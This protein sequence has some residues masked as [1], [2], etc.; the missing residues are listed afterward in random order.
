VTVAPPV[1]SAEAPVWTPARS[2]EVATLTQRALGPFG[3]ADGQ[4]GLVAWL[5]QPARGDGQ[6]LIDV[7]LAADGAPLSQPHAVTRVPREATS[8][9]LQSPGG[10]QRGWL[11]GWSALLDRGESLSVLGVAPD[12]SARGAPADVQRTSDHIKWATLVPTP[13]G[14][15]ALWA[16][17]TL[18]GDAN[19]LVAPI[20]AEGKLVSPAA[21]VV[22]GVAGWQAVPAGDG[23]GVALVSM[24]PA[25]DRPQAGSLRWI[26]LDSDGH[27]QGVATAVSRQATVSSDVDV[28]AW[29]DGWLLAWTDRTGEDAQV[30]VAAVDRAGHVT[31]PGPAMNAVGGSVLVALASGSAGAT[32]AWE[33]PH[34]RNRPSRELHLASIPL[35]DELA[36]VP[37][38]SL[39]VAPSSSTELVADDNGFALLVVAR[40]CLAGAGA[41]RC[42]APAAPT[43]VRLDSRLDPIQTEPLFVG[44]DAD[45]RAA[46]AWGLRCLGHGRCAALVASGDAPTPVY[47]VELLPRSSPFVAPFPPPQGADSPHVTGIATLA[48]GQTYD[49]V[50]AAPLGETTLVVTVATAEPR[51]PRRER[52]GRVGAPARIT[53]RAFDRNGQP[54]SPLRTMTSHALPAA[55]MAVASAPQPDDGAVLV[56]VGGEAGSPRIHAARLD[57]AAHASHEVELA[58]ARSEGSD[59]AVAWAGDGWIIAWIDGRAG[60]AEVYAIKVDRQ[61]RRVGHEERIAGGAGDVE[62]IALAVRGDLAWV[63]W[64][65]SRDNPREGIADIFA[66]TIHARDATRAGDEAR[67]LATAR[68]SRSPRLVS[69]PDGGALI[70]WIEDAPTGLDGPGA[71][72]A[73]RIDDAARVIGTPVAL[74]FR[75]DERPT[76]MAV[77]REG[78]G[79]RAVVARANHEGL[80]LDALRLGPDARPLQP[81]SRLLD[82]DAAPT[83]D[84]ALA[85]AGDAVLFDDVG[86]APGARRIRRATVSWPAAASTGP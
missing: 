36:A 63:A 53:L 61:L 82:L 60:R 46:L 20:D 13:K 17:E 66:T 74:P 79:F 77:A 1:A 55:G 42:T 15:L 71:A 28:V 68:H 27:P 12:G 76:A 25:T 54:T 24:A 2:R 29:R 22:A 52:G 7:P 85:L 84:V 9:V 57:T 69:A 14:A 62:D 78:D 47:D 6:E 49:D 21:R 75:A 73:A 83:F 50:V 23:A 18:S 67:V 81:P 11:V 56:W 33:E 59:V 70:A 31:G 5:A 10:T 41:G 8:V 72:M 26:R 86:S 34:A 16:E 58:G 30:M 48:S 44:R 32:L 51:A 35:R 45:T 80:T 40:A 43:F 65:D 37:V 4:G 3:I 38:T 19:I 39:R 64:S